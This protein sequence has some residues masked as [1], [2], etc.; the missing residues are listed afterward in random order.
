M[1]AEALYCRQIMGLTQGGAEELRTRE[2]VDYLGQ[3]LPGDTTINL[4]HWYYASLA[5]HHAAH[6]TPATQPTWQ[7]WNERLQVALLPR[8]ETSG[9][10]NGSWPANT[11]WGGYGGR[12]Y[13]T[14]MATMCLEVYYRYHVTDPEQDPW[15]AARPGR[16]IK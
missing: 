9:A 14:A 1:T 3:D 12:V 2:A 13:S 10:A 4:Y 15:V 5:L 16:V 7:R 6:Q 8:Q 11:V